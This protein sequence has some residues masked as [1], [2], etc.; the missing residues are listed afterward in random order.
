M[1]KAKS[2]G[3]PRRASAVESESMAKEGNA[4][5]GKKF[6]SEG[7]TKEQKTLGQDRFKKATVSYR[8]IRV[9]RDNKEMIKICKVEELPEGA[10]QSLA[11]RIEKKKKSWIVKVGKLND[12]MKALLKEREGI[13]L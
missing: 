11:A 4:E 10:Y 2:I 13:E 9:I 6:I 1:A 5:N 7:K 3:R 8:T 12:E